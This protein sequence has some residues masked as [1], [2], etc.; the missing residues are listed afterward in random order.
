MTTSTI[1]ARRK[2]DPQHH[3][4]GKKSPPMIRK[5]EICA[6]FEVSWGAGSAKGCPGGEKVL[7]PFRFGGR[8]GCPKARMW[9]PFLVPNWLKT[10]STSV[11]K[12]M[13]RNIENDA[14]MRISLQTNDSKV[15]AAKKHLPENW[16]S[17]N[18]VYRWTVFKK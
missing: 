18:G 7:L 9:D 6:S 4:E 3:V 2:G 1:T 17:E 8:R 12:W 16:F 14:K 11:R 10:I 13:Q 15:D 5:N